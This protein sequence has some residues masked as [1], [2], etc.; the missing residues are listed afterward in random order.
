MV[1]VKR[2]VLS[3]A[4]TQL[5]FNMLTPTKFSEDLN[6][7]NLR[8]LHLSLAMEMAYKIAAVAVLVKGQNGDHT[9]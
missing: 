6:Q 9:S 3:S 2:S 4:G 1:F 5:S 7:T 8:G